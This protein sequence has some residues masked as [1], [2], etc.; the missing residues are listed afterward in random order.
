M[1]KYTETAVKLLESL[2]EELQGHVVEELN[3]LVE[4]VRDEVCREHLF[5]QDST[6]RAAARAARQDIASSLAPEMDYDRL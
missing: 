6:L 1:S 2:P 3:A 5:S 4:D